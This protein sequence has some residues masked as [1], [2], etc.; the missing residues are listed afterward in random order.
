[1]FLTYGKSFD[2]QSTEPTIRVFLWPRKKFIGKRNTN[3]NI[4]NK[5]VVMLLLLSN[6]LSSL[7]LIGYIM[8]LNTWICFFASHVPYVNDSKKKPFCMLNQRCKTVNHCYVRRYNYMMIVNDF[9]SIQ[10]LKKRL[11]L[12]QRLLNQEDTCQSR[13]SSPL[14]SLLKHL[15]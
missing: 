6:L 14:K 11:L 8:F 10:V 13:V 15:L 4:K 5:Q 9:V 1:M 3:Y 7:A 2:S 12:M